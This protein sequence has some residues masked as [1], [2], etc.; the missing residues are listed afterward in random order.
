MTALS[1]ELPG[2][3]GANPLGF[4]AALGTLTTLQQAG[5][6]RLCL[7]WKRTHSWIPLIEGISCTAPVEVAESIATGLR[8]REVSV[9][10]EKNRD[11]AQREYETAK[12]MVAK[13]KKEISTRGLGKKARDDAFEK[14]LRP[15]EQSCDELRLRWLVTLK[16]AVPRPE[17]AIGKKLDCTPVEYRQFATDFIR[18]ADGSTRETA[19]LLASFGSDACHEGKTDA[20]VCTPFCF[21]KGSGQQFFLETVRQLMEQVTAERIR[22]TLFDPW[23]YTDERLSMRWDPNEDRRYALMDRNPTTPGNESKTVWMAN[24]LAYRA[25]TLFPCAPGRSGLETTSWT[26][27]NDALAFTWP[28][29]DVP[30]SLD[31]VR[32]LLQLADLV[33]PE[34]HRAELQARGIRAVFRSHRIKVGSG[35]NFKLNFT[36]ARGL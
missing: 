35:A 33:D 36:A 24:L 10:D 26:T 6:K 20:I 4:L 9:Q 11:T 21:I 1:L 2:I 19:D 17:L 27:I 15:L 18:E 34:K 31:T 5:Q 13:K 29:W 30:V 16:K 8:G 14:E 32:S 7:R 28:I 23:H 12:K 25:L 3:D 22:Q